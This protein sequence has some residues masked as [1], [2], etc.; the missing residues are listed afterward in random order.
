MQPPAGAPL[1]L[2]YAS[3]PFPDSE[4]CAEAVSI[5]MRT[6]DRALLLPRALRSVLAQSFTNWRLYL[7]N[8][9]GNPATLENVLAPFRNDFG[10]KLSVINHAASLGMEAAS[11]A[12]L[13][14]ASGRYFAIHDDDDR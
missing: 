11:N 14:V 4:P 10:D 5:I 8:D 6:K 7:V 2:L 1:S 3:Q 13:A 9:G 12:G